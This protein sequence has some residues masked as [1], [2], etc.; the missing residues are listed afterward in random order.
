[1]AAEPEAAR[2]VRRRPSRRLSRPSGPGRGPDRAKRVEKRRIHVAD[3]PADTARIESVLLDAL[4]RSLLVFPIMFEDQI[5]AV[6]ALA[7]LRQFDPAHTTFLEQL[8]AS[9]GIVFNS[10][11]A[12]MQTEGAA[13]AIPAAS[14]RIAVATERTAANQRGARAEGPAAG[15]AQCRGGGQKPGDRAGAPRAG[16]EGDGA[17]VDLQVQV[18]IPGQHEPRAAHAA[19]QH[20]D[21]GPA[22]ER[23]PRSELERAAGGICAHHPC[24]GHR[25]D[26]PDQRHSG[27][28]Q[29]RIRY[30]LGRRRRDLLYEPDRDDRPALPARGRDAAICPSTSISTHISTAASSPTPSAC[31]RS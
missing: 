2:Q 18:G 4:P 26:E 7:S 27:S 24:R 28:V 9:I 23:Q 13:H 25:S 31:S 21:P 6:I 20:P 16:R 11:E 17:V 19:Q 8:T 30:R 1:M 5:K 22:A 3:I 12:T 29:D 15:R 14:D 10:I